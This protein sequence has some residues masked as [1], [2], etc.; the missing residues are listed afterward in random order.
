MRNPLPDIFLR[1]PLAHRALHDLDAWR[2][3][4]SRSAVAAA[5][6]AGYGI[7]IDVQISADGQAMVF[8]DATLDRMTAEAGPIE[9]RDAASLRQISLNNGT[10][11]IPTLSDILALVAGRVPVLVEIKDQHGQMGE[12]EGRLEEAVATAIKR[13]HG[14]LALMSFNPNSMRRLLHLAGDWPR[15]LTTA[16]FDPTDWA[17]LAP[18][19]CDH[20]RAIPD[21]ES[22]G[23]SFLSHEWS[24]LSRPRVRDLASWGADLLCWTVHSPEQEVE[25]RRIA[26]NITF[27]GYGPAFPA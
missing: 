9:A 15:G 19:V 5:M 11:G 26:D 25:A 21:Y 18:E 4:N 3:E 14:P 20:L 10:E 24:D 23:A 1:T 16:A 6:R 27:E 7:E 8:H 13:Y 2:P 17:L 22:V 12:T